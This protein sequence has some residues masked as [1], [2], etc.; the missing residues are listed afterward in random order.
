MSASARAADPRELAV[1][2]VEAARRSGATACDAL[3]LEFESSSSAVRMRAVETVKLSRERRLG[4]RC[5]AGQGTAVASTADL[6]PAAIARLAAE[7]VAMA[8]AVAPDP[9]AGLPDGELL[10]RDT[11]DLELEDAEG[12]SISP[13]ERIDRAARCEAAALDAD[14]RIVNSEGAEFSVRS[15]RLAYASSAGFLGEYRATSYALWA[16]PIAELDGSMQRDSWYDARRALARLASPEE[17]G[18]KAAARALRRLGAR[19]VETQ[20]V[21]VVFDPDMAASLIGHVASAVSGGALYRRT[22]FL[23]DRLGDAIASPLVTIVDDGRLP[24]GLASRPFDAEGV[25]TRRTVVVERGTLSSYLLDTYSAAK[26]GLRTTGNAARSVG[27]VPAAAATNFHLAAG[28]SSPEE[29]IASVPRGLYVT[30]LSGFG[31]NGVTGDYSR[32]AAGLWIEGGELAFPVEEITI[33]G[34]L[35]D[36]LRGIEM[37]GN[38]LSFRSSIVAPT[39]KIG[40]MTLGGR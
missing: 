16:S 14:A 18:R 23:L 19:P 29:I 30:S 31:V 26:L 38:D 6:E 15:S 34:N 20:E 36:M 10:A 4:L 5:F 37:V 28:T 22:S 8:R 9:V 27:D 7:V 33:A 1:E 3:L 40:R 32:G 12:L 25:A 24:A 13:E 35:L 21:P 17:I 2:A 11:P 39:L